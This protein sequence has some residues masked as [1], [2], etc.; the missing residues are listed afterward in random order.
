MWKFFKLNKQFVEIIEISEKH[1]RFY[2][3]LKIKK[4]MEF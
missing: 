4:K 1:Q 2:S 3:L